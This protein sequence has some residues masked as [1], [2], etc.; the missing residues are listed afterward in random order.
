MSVT[1]GS[2]A[3]VR[4]RIS[5]PSTFALVTGL[6]L[7]IGRTVRPRSSRTTSQRISA[8]GASVTSRLAGLLVFDFSAGSS[9]AAAPLVDLA[10]RTVRPKEGTVLALSMSNSSGRRGCLR[11]GVAVSSSASNWDDL[12]EVTP[13]PFA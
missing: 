5:W 7:V 12:I 10:G 4:N 2:S 1:A 9:T 11:R 13:A 6:S 3:V 8:N